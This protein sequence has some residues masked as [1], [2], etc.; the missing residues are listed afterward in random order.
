MKPNQLRIMGRPGAGTVHL[1]VE[2]PGQ[3]PQVI[4]DVTDDFILMQ[5]AEIL[6]E[7]GTGIETLYRVTHPNG[8]VVELELT[9]RLITHA[10]N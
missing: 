3:K 8:D 5:A 9:A 1:I 6:R 7:G 2:K 10:R 4:K